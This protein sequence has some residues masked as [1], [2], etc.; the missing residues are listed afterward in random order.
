ML[1]AAGSLGMGAAPAPL[2][3]RVQQHCACNLDAVLWVTWPEGSLPDVPRDGGQAGL[4][5]DR[6]I[7]HSPSVLPR[8][9]ARNLPHVSRAEEALGCPNA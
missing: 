2:R 4:W 5:P 7:R 9:V 8:L 6:R 3:G 1:R